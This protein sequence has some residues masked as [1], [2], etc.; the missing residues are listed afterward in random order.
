MVLGAD[1]AAQLFEDIVG[2]LL[3]YGYDFRIKLAPGATDDLGPGDGEG[4][5]RSIGTVRDDGV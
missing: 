1:S 2:H 4:T 3:E 5:G